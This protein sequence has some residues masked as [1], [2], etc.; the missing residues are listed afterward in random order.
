MN[1]NILEKTIETISSFSLR[2]ELKEL[3]KNGIINFEIKKYSNLNNS[4]NGKELIIPVYGVYKI[5]WGFYQNALDTFYNDDKTE[6]S[7]IINNT[8]HNEK[9]IITRET[10]SYYAKKSSHKTLTVLLRENEVI[11]LEAII[12]NKENPKMKDVYLNV[13]KLDTEEHPQFGYEN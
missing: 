10:P 13:E 4:W 7:L 11:S 5:S 1:V 6:L 9:A 2:V 8:K 3:I 12:L